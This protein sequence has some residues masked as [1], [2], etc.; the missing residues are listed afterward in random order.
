MSSSL[1]VH[2]VL[3]PVVQQEKSGS[4]RELPSGMSDAQ[5]RSQDLHPAPFS[6]VPSVARTVAAAAARSATKKVHEYRGIADIRSC[7]KAR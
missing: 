4:V 2:S 3:S 1:H 6:H 5:Q 7:T